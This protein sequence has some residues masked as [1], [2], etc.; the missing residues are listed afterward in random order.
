MLRLAQ[1][2]PS[3]NTTYA[4]VPNEKYDKE[5]LIGKAIKD[6]R[7]GPNNIHSWDLEMKGKIK[8]KI[9]MKMRMG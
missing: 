5:F 7:G 8:M 3:L 4:D 6:R 9:K 1:V 2:G